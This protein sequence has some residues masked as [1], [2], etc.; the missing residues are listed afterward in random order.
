MGVGD[1][2]YEGRSYAYIFPDNIFAKA[3]RGKKTE[4]A[5]V[6]NGAF[7]F[8]YTAFKNAGKIYGNLSRKSNAEIKQLDALVLAIRRDLKATANRRS[9]F[10]DLHWSFNHFKSN[11]EAWYDENPDGW[12][13]KYWIPS[14]IA[15]FLYAIEE[16]GG[17][18]ASTKKEWQQYSAGLQA[19][20]KAK[21]WDECGKQIGYAEQAIGTAAP[22]LWTLLGRRQGD[23]TSYMELGKTWLGYAAKVHNASDL[24]LKLTSS[25]AGVKQEMFVTAMSS[26]V[27][28]LPVFGTLY[29]DVIKS[30][31]GAMTY[32]SRLAQRTDRAIGMADYGT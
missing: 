30:V 8:Y 9:F 23:A 3:F 1:M 10:H 21:K 31:P 25:T 6:M 2:Y 5:N 4:V 27:S 26:V 14:G 28:G 18:V 22:M 15:D 12:Q 17:K 24:Y 7:L 20:A 29:G 11:R 16:R 32:F 19:A 13:G